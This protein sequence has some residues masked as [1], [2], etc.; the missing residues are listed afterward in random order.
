MINLKKL[1]EKIA[2]EGLHRVVGARLAQEGFK[3]SEMVDLK[4]A[5]QV[6]GTKLYEKNAEYRRIVEG[7]ASLRAL[8]KEE[9]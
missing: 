3:L 4:T 6:L 9:A 7:I 1:Q 5:V 8:E 2:R